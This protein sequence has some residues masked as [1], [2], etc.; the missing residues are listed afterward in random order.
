MKSAPEV[1]RAR[2]RLVRDELTAV[3]TAVRRFMVA[4]RAGVVSGDEE[5]AELLLRDKFN[6]GARDSHNAAGKLAMDERSRHSSAP[7]SAG[8]AHHI[9]GVEFRRTRALMTDNGMGNLV[10]RIEVWEITAA[11][12][13]KRRSLDG[14]G[15]KAAGGKRSISEVRGRSGVGGGGQGE[16]GRGGGEGVPPVAIYFADRLKHFVTPRHACADHWIGL[17][18]RRLGPN[19]EHTNR[20]PNFCQGKRWNGAGLCRR[21]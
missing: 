2:V 9:P 10:E 18:C 3:A 7:L 12:L 19:R 13:P 11:R 15:S 6:C 16:G 1:C 20:H 8:G 14:V 21:R 5:R 17:V 4:Y